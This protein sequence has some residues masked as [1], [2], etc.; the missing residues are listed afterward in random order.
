MCAEVR[1]YRPPVTARPLYSSFAWA[2]D[3]VV[4]SPGGPEADVIAAELDRRG[5][6]PPAPVLDA[7]CGSGRYAGPLAAAGYTVTGIDRSPELIAVASERVRGASFEV[8]DLRD[9]APPMPFDAALCRGVLN[10]MTSDGDR[11][12]A[13]SGLRRALRPGGI[14]IADVRDWDAS[15]DHY[16]EHPV[17]ERRVDTDRGQLEFRSE[18]TLDPGTRTL[19]VAERIALAGGA[20]EFDFAMRCWTRD[21][22]AATL[23]DAGF[24]ALD[25]DA[26]RPRRPDRIVVVATVP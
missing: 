20:E 5:I 16:R 19:G 1:R 23:L 18:T 2:Y 12:A 21:E 15:V 7:G 17:F 10:D 11:R 6:A 24:A 25:L 4:A 14:L 9:W 26:L 13:V 8:A 22:L 3:L